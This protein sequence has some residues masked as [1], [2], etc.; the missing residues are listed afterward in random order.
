MNTIKDCF[1]AILH[2]NEKE[3]RLA[4]RRVR[5]LLYS[6][7]GDREKFGQ[8]KDIVNSASDVYATISEDWR[9]ENFVLAVSVVYYLHDK[10]AQP[11]FLFP[12]LFQL[13]RHTNGYIRHAAVKMITNELGP[14]TVHLRFPGERSFTNEKLTPEQAD[15][16]LHSLFIS[17]HQLTSFLWQPKYKRY[18]YIDSLPASPYK[19]VQMVLAEL[20]EDCGKEYIDRLV[21]YA[22]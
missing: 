13:L 15:I 6:A 19:S 4:A 9:Q 14:L 7:Q 11:D 3:S 21:K 22:V 10:E 17:L 20:E 18:K 16:I 12:W 2:G 1:D 5:K 8:I